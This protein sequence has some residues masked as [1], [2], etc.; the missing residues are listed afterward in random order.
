MFTSG[1]LDLEAIIV[2]IYNNMLD[3]IDRNMPNYHF[4]TMDTII[5]LNFKDTIQY[6]TKDSIIKKFMIICANYYC[7]YWYFF[8]KIFTMLNKSVRKLIKIFF[9]MSGF[10]HK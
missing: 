3:N 1:Y 2:Y 9:K 6:Y 7:K 4:I 5:E 10:H 8:I